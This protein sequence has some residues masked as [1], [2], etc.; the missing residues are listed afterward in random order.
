MQN[1]DKNTCAGNV[2]MSCLPDCDDSA[3]EMVIFELVVPRAAKV[4]APRQHVEVAKLVVMQ[5]SVTSTVSTQTLTELR[6]NN[7]ALG[8]AWCI[9]AT[10]AAPQASRR[11]V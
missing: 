4:P 1:T 2:A 3:E 6:A 11:R 9:T 5:T 10:L 7:T 8:A